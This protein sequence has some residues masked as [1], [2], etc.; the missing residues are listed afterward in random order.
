MSVAAAEELELRVLIE[1]ASARVA[2]HNEEELQRM[3]RR[4][5]EL[6]SQLNALLDP[7]QGLPL[8]IS[9]EIFMQCTFPPKPPRCATKILRSP[10]QHASIAVA[11]APMILLNICHA[12][13]EIALATPGLWTN[14]EVNLP[15]HE[16]FDRLF[17]I[18][19]ARAGHR[20]MN[21]SLHGCFKDHPLHSGIGRPTCDLDLFEFLLLPSLMILEIFRVRDPEKVVDLLKR[22]SP[23]LCYLSIALGLWRWLDRC[24]P[25]V[26]MLQHL[27]VRQTWEEDVLTILAS[28]SPEQ[29]L[30]NFR[31]LRIFN[32]LLPVD[33]LVAVLEYRRSHH[34][35]LEFPAL[36]VSEFSG[37]DEPDFAREYI[38]DPLRRFESETMKIHVGATSCVNYMTTT[39]SD[40]IS[41]SDEH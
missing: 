4:K 26:P 15:R 27:V 6:Q 9:S 35:P 29:Y 21:I 18:W 34:T 22:S 25:L 24:F 19:L 28:H 17:E 7:V 3:Q 30:P 16:E 1:E 13:T 38:V 39:D 12:W 5:R 14:I 36:F 11:E 32:F 31:T 41:R 20:S 2:H 33:T 8:E 10:I 37:R 23:P 40:E